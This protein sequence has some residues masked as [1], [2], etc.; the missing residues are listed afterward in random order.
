[1]KVRAISKYNRIG[2]K[3]VRTILDLIKNKNPEVAVNILEN[4]NKK[5]AFLLLKV[6]KSCIANA[7]DKK[8]EVGKLV[9]TDARADGGPILKRIQ[10]RAMGRADRIQKRTTHITVELSEV[11]SSN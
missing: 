4:M 6:L 5:S 2:P 9:V 7:K 1:M 11:N 10:P 8:I 3:K